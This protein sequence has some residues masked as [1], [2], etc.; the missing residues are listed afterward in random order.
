MKI[1]FY[2]I[3]ISALLGLAAC[4]KTSQT[5]SE[6]KHFAGN[7]IGAAAP[8]SQRY[9]LATANGVARRTEFDCPNLSAF[10]K[11]G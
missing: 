3:A 1:R 5:V 11:S 9:R 2:L 7:L 10:P 4:E 8:Q 6:V